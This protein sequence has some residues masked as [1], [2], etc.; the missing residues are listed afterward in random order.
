[1]NDD[2]LHYLTSSQVT[3]CRLLKKNKLTVQCE[4]TMVTAGRNGYAIT[5]DSSVFKRIHVKHSQIHCHSLIQTWLLI[6]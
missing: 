2:M 3:L 1:M 5:R 6:L 4:G